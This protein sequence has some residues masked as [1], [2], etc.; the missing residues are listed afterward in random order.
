MRLIHAI[1][2]YLI[3]RPMSMDISI[4]EGVVLPHPR[5]GG[6]H[7]RTN[8]WRPDMGMPISQEFMTGTLLT[9]S[10]VVLDGLRKLGVRASPR[11]Q[12]AYLHRW[13]ALGWFMGIDERILAQLD[14]PDTAGATFDADRKSVV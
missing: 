4:R 1:V 9:F 12:Q 2:R 10:H 14:D 5:G 8:D 7:Q 11:E 6:E 13:N 3:V